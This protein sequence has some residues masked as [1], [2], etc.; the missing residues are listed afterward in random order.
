MVCLATFLKNE[1]HCVEHMLG[2]VVEHVEEIVAVVDWATTDRT[3]EI[4]QDFG[5]RVYYA[6]FTNFG[7]VR[8]L[9]AHLARSPWVLMLDGDE[10]L[11]GPELIHGLI[12]SGKSKA[13]AFPRKRWLDLEMERQTEIHAYPDWQ[14]RL[15]RNSE[16][17]IWKRELHEYFHGTSVHHVEDGPVIHHFQDV[18]KDD[19]RQQERDEL[20]HRLAHQA[21]VHMIGGLPLEE[22]KC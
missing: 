6:G 10:T 19:A 12:R 15:F 1:A 9:A 8:T 7:N 17:Y 18:F 20:Y 22:D 2:S 14:V 21:K 4:L 3:A 5:A 16:D 13:Y 11:E